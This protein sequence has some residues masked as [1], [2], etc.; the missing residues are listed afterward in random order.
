[1]KIILSCL[2]LVM[3]SV[4]VACGGTAPA[5]PTQAAPTASSTP[6]ASA[7]STATIDANLPPEIPNA[8]KGKF[9]ANGKSLYIECVGSGSPTIVLENGEGMQSS[10]MLPFKEKLAKRMTTC[11]YDRANVGNS[12]FGA[13]RPRKGAEIVQDLHALL[14]AAQVPGP[15]LLMGHSAG[16]LIVQLYARKFPNNIIG[17]VSMNPVPPAHPWLDQVSQVFSTQEYADEKDYYAGANDEALDYAAISKELA[18]APNPPS[19]PFEMLLS[20]SA[21]CEEPDGPCMKSYSIY[22]Q[23]ERDVAAAWPKGKF[24]QVE[25]EHSIFAYKPE[26]VLSAIDSILA[27]R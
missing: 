9:M 15:Y 20:T 25:S 5:A 26:A 10:A 22:E 7:T 2:A 16:G 17:V 4:L 19:V 3:S 18:D 21:Q 14:V 11:V 8:V 24:S 12:E 1:M 23:I 27:A 13:A 6:T